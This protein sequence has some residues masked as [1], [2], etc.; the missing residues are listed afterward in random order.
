M[1]HLRMNLDFAVVLAQ[2]KLLLWAEILVAE[3]D[4]AALGD[5]KSEFISLLVGQIFELETDDFCAN[6]CGKVV[7]FFR[8]REE[9]SLVLVR[10]SAGV[11]IFSV[12]VPD[13]VDVLEEQG[14]SWAVLGDVSVLDNASRTDQLT[15]Y[16]SLRSMPAFSS[17]ALVGPG[18][19]R[20]SF[21]GWT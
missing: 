13:G 19:L 1:R 20:L 4:D 16:P 6:V 8:G 7:D 2:L 15:G 10:T 14:T 18:R 12:F 3:K 5:Q 9:C 17:L 11:D 21:L